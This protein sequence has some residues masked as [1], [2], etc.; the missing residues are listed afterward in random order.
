VS[1]VSFD[2]PEWEAWWQTEVLP[3]V[4]T[5][6]CIG[7]GPGP[8]NV[9]AY[10]EDGLPIV[11]SYRNWKRLQKESPVS[12][13]NLPYIVTLGM[14]QQFKKDGAWQPVV[15]T[16][17]VNGQ[18][19]SSF[20]IKTISQKL[21]SVSLWPEFA[22]LV[23]HIVKGAGVFVE[24]KLREDNKGNGVIYYNLSASNISFVAPVQRAEREVVNQ[25]PAP[26][27]APTVDPTAAPAP[28]AAAPAPAPASAGTIF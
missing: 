16:N 23:P 7:P 21:I 28:V 10:R 26:V 14:V 20:M 4:W 6:H 19:V 17:D 2:S 9:M 15:R 18:A 22:H 11:F 27:A 25:Q 8:K 24:G 12:E 5:F 1:I 3:Y 13:E